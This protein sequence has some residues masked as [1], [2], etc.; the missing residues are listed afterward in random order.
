MSED[1]GQNILISDAFIKGK[2]SAAFLLG[3]FLSALPDAV[4]FL[5]SLCLT[6]AWRRRPKTCCSRRWAGTTALWTSSG[7]R[8]G[9]RRPW[10]GCCE[11]S[12]TSTFHFLDSRSDTRRNATRPIRTQ[13][14]RAEQV[15][16][17]R[18]SVTQSIYQSL[19]F[20]LLTATFG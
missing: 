8:T 7:R 11:Y 9:R 20:G 19:S 14:D 10:R 2:M 18:P 6:G 1:G 16:E 4:L 12:H 17:S 5:Q 3:S 15:V 13:V